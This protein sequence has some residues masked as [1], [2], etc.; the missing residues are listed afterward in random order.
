MQWP[1]RP[2]LVPTS[3]LQ[4]PELEGGV[5]SGREA[6]AAWWGTLVMGRLEVLVGSPSCGEGDTGEVRWGAVELL[7][8]SLG[9]RKPFPERTGKGSGAAS[10]SWSCP[11]P[12]SGPLL[13]GAAWPEGR[14]VVNPGKG[15][16]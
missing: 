8:S 7:T 9:R 5:W 12:E 4:S 14:S 15:L 1:E 6:E 2:L 11:L 16:V 3:W 13:G 10:C